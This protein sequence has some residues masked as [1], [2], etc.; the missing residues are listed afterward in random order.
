[1]KAEGSAELVKSWLDLCHLGSLGGRGC[2]RLWSLPLQ[3]LVQLL[4]RGRQLG[5][6]G[7]MERGALGLPGCMGHIVPLRKLL[8]GLHHEGGSGN[9]LLLKRLPHPG[10]KALIKLLVLR[11]LPNGLVGEMAS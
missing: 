6:G 1:M 7:P 3:D 11:K 2:R 4:V 10:V 9:L 5:V 8:N